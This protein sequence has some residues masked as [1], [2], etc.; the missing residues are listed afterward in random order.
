VE[1]CTE[2]DKKLSGEL[3]LLIGTAIRQRNLEDFRAAIRKAG[4]DLSDADARWMFTI[5]QRDLP[6][7]CQAWFEQ[8]IAQIQRGGDVESI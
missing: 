7:D 8:A 5:V 3:A 2:A 4:T 1:Y 6:P